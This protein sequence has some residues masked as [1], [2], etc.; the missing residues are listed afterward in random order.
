MRC[1]Q[2]QV[3]MQRTPDGPRWVVQHQVVVELPDDPPSSCTCTVTELRFRRSA[4]PVTD[5][6][7]SATEH[8]RPLPEDAARLSR[9][10]AEVQVSPLVDEE[11]DV[12]VL[13]ISDPGGE[14]GLPGNVAFVAPSLGRLWL[15]DDPGRVIDTC[16]VVVPFSAAP[17][18]APTFVRRWNST[19]DVKPIGVR[20]RLHSQT[21]L[22]I[23]D[24]RPGR[25]GFELV[26]TVFVHP[27]MWLRSRWVFGRFPAVVCAPGPGSKVYRHRGECEITSESLDSG[28]TIYEIR[29]LEVTAGPRTPSGRLS[30]KRFVKA[31]DRFFVTPPLPQLFDLRSTAASRLG[32]LAP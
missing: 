26:H 30:K 10:T 7:P 19:W 32:E 8:T 23:D 27:L 22:T 12:E 17:P 24:L 5:A 15:F 31:G 29:V 11:L 20:E 6:P 14:L 2:T 13:R 25:R 28:D 16:R 4:R 3:E 1:V 18:G 9:S 21:T